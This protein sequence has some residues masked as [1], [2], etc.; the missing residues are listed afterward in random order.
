MLRALTV[1]LLTLL[2]CFVGGYLATWGDYAVPATVVDDPALPQQTIDGLRL[3]VE[4]FG[5]AN[6]ATVIVVHGG[7]GGDYRGLLPL[8]ALADRYRVVFYDQRGS[9][10]SERPNSA[11]LTLAAMYRELEQLI[12]RVAGKRPVVLVGHSWGAM[13]AVGFAARTPQR[14]A[15]LVLAE[16]GMLTTAAATH[17][18]KA[19]NNMRPK[20]GLET[21]FQLSKIWFKSLH[22]KGDADAR[23][24]FFFSQVFNA[25]IADHPLAGYFCDRRLDR[26]ALAY[27]RF[28]ARVSQQLLS[29]ARDGQGRIQLDF[30]SGIERFSRPVL[31]I[32]GSCNTLIGEAFQRRFHLPHLV[33]AKLKVIAGAG[34]T[35]FGEK[36]GPSV[37]LVRDYLAQLA[38]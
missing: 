14:V 38:F 21:L 3:H 17:L 24:D 20:I 12:E 15:A 5:Q 35:M 10:L 23:A 32:V 16:P 25:P 7:P 11:Q 9:G 34:H 29:Q 18:M 33:S 8:R 36:P 30:V 31:V 1:A 37:K 4:V 22:V 6:P 19:T 28:G 26:A 2:L 13:L 27:W